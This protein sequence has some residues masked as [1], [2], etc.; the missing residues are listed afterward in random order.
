MEGFAKLDCGC[1]V[2]FDVYHKPMWGKQCA[3]HKS[4]PELYKALKEIY[5][6]VGKGEECIDTSRFNLITKALQ[7]ADER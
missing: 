6:G 1:F 4:A 3:L 2:G 7:K 5:E